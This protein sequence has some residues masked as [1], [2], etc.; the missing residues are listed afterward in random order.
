MRGI[1]IGVL[2]AL[3]VSGPAGAADVTFSGTITGVC[4]L[5]L[6]TPGLLAIS[7]DGSKL[8]S[9]EP[10]GLPALVTIL[11]VGNATVT[12]D[13]PTRTSAPTALVAYVATGEVVEV[14]Y[15][16][17]SGLSGITRAYTTSQ[18]SFAANT[19]PLTV[20]Q[21]NNRITN[22]LGFPAGT[23]TTKTVVTCS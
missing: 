22:N 10:G 23:Y 11:S 17:L 1:C 7:T 21:V 6:G 4:A 15:Q 20:L 5:A 9:Q 13:P 16:G 19:L 8:G 3:A 14:A 12:V 18:T 2:A